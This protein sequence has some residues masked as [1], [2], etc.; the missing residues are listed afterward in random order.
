LYLIQAKVVDIS[1]KVGYVSVKHLSQVF[2]Q[3]FQM[4]PGEYQDKQAS[5]AKSQ[6][7]EP[8]IR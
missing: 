5:A 7:H 3:Y 4:P 1:E 2:K 6:F 8:T